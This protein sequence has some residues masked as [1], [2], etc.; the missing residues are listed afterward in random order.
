MLK[1]RQHTDSHGDM[2]YAI[3]QEILILL[4]V[5]VVA[6]A[7]FRR[8]H[9]PPILG[10]LVVG[11]M[12][13]PH[14]LQWIPD[15]TD[16]RF[17]AEFGVVFLLFTVG[18]EFS[19]PQLVAMKGAVLGLGGA[20]VA[21]STAVA[22]AAAW[23]LGMGWEGALITGGILALSSTAIVI[24]QLTEQLESN[25]RHGRQAIGILLF[26]DLAVIPFLVMIPILAG[27]GGNSV[28]AP[29]LWALVKG[30]GAF[31]VMLALGHWF[32]RPLFRE[33]ASARS[34]ELFMLTILLVSLTA[35]WATHAAGLSFALG[36]FLAGAM[37][38]ETEFRH[39]IEADIRPFRDVLLG[40][41]FVTVGM[42]LDVRA[43]GQIWYWVLLLVAAMVAGKTLLVTGLSRLAGTEIGVALRTGVV[44]AQGG[45]FGFAL[46]SLAIGAGLIGPGEGQVVLGAVVVSM[47]MAPMLIHFNGAIAKRV[48]AASYLGTRAQMEQDIAS[49]GNELAGHVLICGFG[50]VG[51]NI[52]RFLDAEK[53]PYIALDLD[54]KRVREA[55]EAGDNVFYG[56]STHRE[57]LRAA[58]LLRARVLVVSYD[59]P[60]AS[61]RVIAVARSLRA[62]LPILVRT[63]DDSH[64]DELQA[65]GATEVVP[66]TMEASLML[67]SHLLYLM[68][69]PISSIV[70]RVQRV[71]SDRYR[72]LQRVFPDDEPAPQ[73]E[74]EGPRERLHAV[75]LPRGAHAVGRTLRELKLPG[76]TVTAVRHSGHRLGN[77]D[78]NAR[79]D[80]GDVVVML[81]TPANL[82]HGENVLLKG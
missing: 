12:V 64:L 9:L 39:Q 23:L 52:A 65:Q 49:A 36:G 71:R 2:N 7:A 35:A 6:V 50:R 75:T 46:L 54:P 38:G 70:R 20:Q 18:L 5:A 43:L 32:L 73:E 3:F 48:F 37:L 25:S 16:T 68:D 41:F 17:L 30:L 81:G 33:I 15:T 53:F 42:L 13:G 21:I 51:Q 8:L 82:E 59:D 72:M 77:P 60:P 11:M 62:E 79:L 67:A 78:P 1:L 24:K 63:R 44:L 29:L 69:V 10:Y 55:H 47:A 61:L 56:D 27:D 40:L 76:I 14:G 45:E 58:G 28:A 34:S 66:E 26:Q 31:L 80:E 74:Q 22:G 4:A 19:L 57:I